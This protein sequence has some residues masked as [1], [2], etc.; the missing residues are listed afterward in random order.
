MMG[1]E[2]TSYRDEVLRLRVQLQRHE[3]AAS[4]S[5]GDYYYGDVVP[6][7]AL[8]V[9]QR[10]VSN[11]SVGAGVKA[12]ASAVDRTASSLSTLLRRY[13][14]GRLLLLVYVI[15]IHVYMYALTAQLQ[16]RAVAEHAVAVLP[17]SEAAAAS[18]GASGTLHH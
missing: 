17:G 7:D 4:S 1:R 9:Y 18:G 2:L 12:M 16:S 10:L 11:R 8:P 3:S 5:R 6:M 13:P 14:L 15:F